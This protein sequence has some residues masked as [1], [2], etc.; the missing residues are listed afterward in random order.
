M[1]EFEDYKKETIRLTNEVRNM[2][3]CFLYPFALIPMI[4]FI[5][6]ILCLSGIVFYWESRWK[7]VFLFPIVGHLGLLV[8]YFW[9]GR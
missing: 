4:G 2:V 3:F 1:S 7:W 5:P 8:W 6:A 9:E